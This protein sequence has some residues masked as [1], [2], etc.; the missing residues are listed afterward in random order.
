MDN[1]K[2]VGKKIPKIDAPLK[3]TGAALY[4]QD[5]KIPG[6]LHG[7]I[8][9]SQYPHARIIK[10]DTSKAEKLPGV[11]AVVTAKDMPPNFRIGIMKD[12]P[13][14]KSG[15]VLS[16]RD[17]IAAV[18]ATT[19]EIAEEALSLIEVEYEELP[20]IFDPLEA[21]KEGAMLI[22]EEAKS[23]ILKMPWRLI[24]GD[25][26]KAKQESAYIVEDT[27]STQWVTHCCLGTSGCVAHFDMHNNLTM[28]SNTQI[29]SLA[30]ND[31]V[32][33]LNAFGLKNRRVRIIQ[34]VIGGGFGSKLDTYAYEYIAIL[35]ALKTRK[36][37]KIIFTREEEFF[38]TSPRQCTITKISHGCDKDGRLT[39]RDVEMVL[40]NGAYTSWGATTPSVMMLPISSL[41]KVPNVRYIAKCVYTNN[42]YCQAMRGY[43]NPQAT[44]AIESSLDQLAEKAGIDP[45]ELR[46]INANE[47]GEIT[48]QRFK[49]T[50]CGMKECI[51]EVYKRLNWKEKR[52]KDNG[53]GVGMASLIHVGG[54]ARVYKSD[55]CGTIIKMD[56]FGKVDV[57]TGASDIGQGSDTVIA[58]I[59]A[60]VIGIPIEDVNVINNDTDICPWDVGVHASRTTFV[61]GNAALGAARKIREQI[62]EAAGKILD[63]DPAD[64]DIKDGM[65]FSTKNKE[66]STPLGKAL[67]KIHYTLGGKMLMAEYFYDPANEN[68][69][70]EFKGNLSV[71]YAYGAHGVEVEVDRETG[72]VKILNYVAAHDVGK[73]INPLLLE[74]QIYGGGLQ[75]IGYA[76]GEKMVYQNGRLMNGNF[77]DYK[78]PTAKDVPPIQPVIVET[79]EKD[80]PFGAKGIG[81]PGLVP[82]AP[83]I[84]NAIYDAIGV[85]IKD[86]PITPE[87]ILAALKAKDK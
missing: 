10:L 42:T 15:K 11:R 33:A 45:L 61:A 56:D 13:P 30:Q 70:K 37:V 85:R 1:L 69:D 25:V 8:L 84:A 12:N 55:G 7:K 39:F 16:I 17:E 40:D 49:I 36:P 18:A 48:P 82:T 76:L 66:K 3:A 29:P 43:G 31:F 83:A 35:L 59:V 68:F 53:R 87:K 65:V 6:M 44:F 47:P 2:V 23:N 5:V 22:H 41:Y 86:L 21:M 57:F 75:G 32:E 62:L 4:I 79:D 27:F 72:K 19:P 80:G 9:Y 50:S 81:E 26:E 71:S 52:G 63:E 28:Y 24:C 73:A 60:E 58:Q 51:E 20:G 64:L 34:A 67:R 54:G 46:R 78:I 74:G 14:L 38:A 77:L